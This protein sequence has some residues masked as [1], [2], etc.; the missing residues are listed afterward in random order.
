MA[1]VFKSATHSGLGTGTELA[2]GYLSL[3]VKLPVPEPVAVLTAP[4]AVAV[5]DAGG[6]LAV[7]AAKA[8][9]DKV[10]AAKKYKPL[11]NISMEGK[12]G[13]K[14]KKINFRPWTL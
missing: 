10:R 11:N 8:E 7:V 5:E 9:P 13:G 1:L 3:K 2:A 4:D 6:A 14:I 12:E